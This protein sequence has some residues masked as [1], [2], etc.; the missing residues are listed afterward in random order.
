[1]LTRSPAEFMTPSRSNLEKESERR[2][3]PRRTDPE[4]SHLV[5]LQNTVAQE[6]DRVTV[7]FTDTAID[8]GCGSRPYNHL[9]RRVARQVIGVDLDG[10]PLAD[11][12]YKVGEPVPLPDG[13]ADLVVSFQVLEHVPDP[14]AYI[15]EIRRLLRPKGKLVLSAPGFWPYHPHPCDYRRWLRDGLKL[16]IETH[17]FLVLRITPVLQGW[18]AGVQILLSLLRYTI[19]KRKAC[20]WALKG[21]CWSFSYLI[22]ALERWPGQSAPLI[23]STYVVIADKT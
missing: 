13:V 10:N 20:R 3:R 22:D 1:M 19:W 14:K 16:E 5:R 11:L 23:S 8:F 6:L 7:G 2:W 18:S 21:V 12:T 4:Y 17:G 15:A 9:L